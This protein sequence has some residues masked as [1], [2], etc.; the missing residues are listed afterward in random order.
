MDEAVMLS[1]CRTPIGS[2]GTAMVIE[3]A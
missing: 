1:A 2:F 3:V